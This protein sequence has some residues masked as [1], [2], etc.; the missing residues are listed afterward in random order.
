M[1][2]SLSVKWLSCLMVLVVPAA[3]MMAE[4]NAA[5]LYVRGNAM[6]NGSNVP[7]SSAIFAGDKI[8][9]S[10][11]SSVTLASDGTTV[12][13]PANSS[14]VFQGDAIEVGSGSAVVTTSKGWKTHVDRYTVSPKDASAKYE[15]TDVNGKIFV[16]S[17]QGYVTIADASTTKVLGPG[18]SEAL[19]GTASPAAAASPQSGGGGGGGAAA[20]G[21]GVSKA[22]IIAI[23]VGAAAAAAVAAAVS[24]SGSSPS[25]TTPTPTPTSPSAP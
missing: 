7:R 10:S 20:S 17:H 6:L 11:T 2:R 21:G 3:L 1:R 12:L 5:M 4:T 8:Q 22:L 24:A 14:V 19:D 13:V 9:T 16:A 15:V 25:T 23:G 18:K